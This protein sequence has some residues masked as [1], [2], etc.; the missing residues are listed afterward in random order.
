MHYQAANTRTLPET[1]KK[2]MEIADDGLGAA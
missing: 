1:L 2:A